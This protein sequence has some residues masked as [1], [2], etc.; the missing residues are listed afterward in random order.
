MIKWLSSVKVSDHESPSHYYYHDN[1]NFPTALSYEAVNAEDWWKR[2]EYII[3]EMN[4]N[5]VITTPAHGDVVPVAS[6][7]D[8]AV[9]GYAYS[10]GGRRVIIV[11][12]SLDDGNT[13]EM[14]TFRDDDLARPNPFGK[15]W[16]W[17][18]WER[19]V[20]V[21]RLVGRPSLVV[22]AWDSAFNTQPEDVTW[23]V[24]GMMCN[25]R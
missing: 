2:P 17:R 9:S 16:T 1:R 4:I 23:N 15:F 3:G 13:W 11:E 5:S 20:E 24:L 22:R 18:L 6:S 14:A 25:A 8:I 10:G 12:L 21:T 19:R 7:G